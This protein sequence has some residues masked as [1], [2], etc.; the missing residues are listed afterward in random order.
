M[1]RNN[2]TSLARRA[3]CATAMATA[4]LCLATG[5]AVGS[6]LESARSMEQSGD[7]AGALDAYRSWIGSDA[8]HG[9]EKR[10]VKIRMPVLEEAKKLGA[11]PDLERF[12][13]ALSDRAADNI[14][15]ALDK[16]NTLLTDYPDSRLRDDSRYLIGY[17]QMMDEFD[18]GA[19]SE[20]METLQRDFPESRYFDTALY[21]QAIAQ[22]QLGNNDAA[23]NLFGKLRD[24]HTA[25]SI[26]SFDL[27][28]P[29]STL[30]SRYWFDRSDDRLKRIEHA[31]LNA[32]KVIERTESD[33]TDY[34]VRLTVSA[35]GKR[36]VLLVKPSSILQGTEI[37]GDADAA[38]QSASVETLQ[39]IIEGEAESWARVTLQGDTL[40]GVISVQGERI[41]L[42][43]AATAGTLSDYN[44]LLRSDIDGNAASLQDDAHGAPPE[45]NAIDS[46]LRSIRQY[47]A[48]YTQSGGVTHVARVG[49]VIDS[50]YNDYHGGNGFQ[51]ALSIL[52]TTDGIFRE[53][54]GIAL[55]IETVIVIADRTRDTMNIGRVEMVDMMRN[56]RNYRLS[57]SVLAN[58]DIGLATLFSGNKNSDEPLGL[59]WI[60]TACRTDGYDVSVV[61]PFSQPVLLSTHELAHTL[62]A[63]H[64]YS[65]SC[66]EG[67]NLMS[68]HLSGAIDQTFSSC[69]KQEIAT[70]L[71]NTSCHSD[72]ID[73]AVD[74]GAIT[75]E[76]VQLSVLNN[77]MVRSVPAANLR[78]EMKDIASAEFPDN[79]SATD[80]DSLLCQ[81]GAIQSIDNQQITIALPESIDTSESV[82]AY[83]EPVGYRDIQNN[84][85]AKVADLYGSVSAF[86]EEPQQ[87]NPI[88]IADQSGGGTSS[89]GVTVGGGA[90]NLSPISMLILGLMAISQFRVLPRVR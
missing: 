63:N 31:Q 11:G 17:I 13:E 85:N 21:S 62:G 67:R 57:N 28:W 4:L 38:L 88:V 83:A 54:L 16:L 41:P 23:A 84:N 76:E 59:A 73:L 90:G 46:Y 35:S 34:P 22:E 14:P 71:A 32:A 80:N 27:Y 86:V 2:P 70:V 42:I 30:G 66:G 68:R 40:S 60:G 49:V 65:T 7:Y 9:A 1:H 52:N 53:E 18:F 37:S 89:T 58:S 74:F 39:G 72:A 6:T 64:D 25:M 87:I 3:A 69:S 5:P 47:D 45:T 56:F 33:N 75:P 44:T 29:R 79:C 8:A 81:F 43:G 24:R 15:A 55:H 82:T 10:Y 20:A 36:H 26:K 61:T 12:L 50:Q 51:E 19:A 77:D 48:D 78:V